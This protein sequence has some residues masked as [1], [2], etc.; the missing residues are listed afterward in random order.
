[1]ISCQIEKRW[2]RPQQPHGGD[3][4]G[5]AVMVF[6]VRTRKFLT[7]PLLGRSQFV[8]DILHPGAT[9]VPKTDIQAKLASMYKV[10]DDKTVVVFGMKHQFGGGKTTGFGCIYENLKTLKQFEPMHRQLKLGVAEAKKKLGRRAKKELKG[11]LKKLRGTK[12]NDAKK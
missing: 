8:V 12:K 10:K 1:M 4:L 2:W 3:F 11:K 6:T 7:N 9:T 5:G